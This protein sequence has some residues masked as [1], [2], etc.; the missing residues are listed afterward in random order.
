[1][2]DSSSSSSSLSFSFSLSAVLPPAVL[3]PSA[4][5]TASEEPRLKKK[6]LIFL[7]SRALTKIFG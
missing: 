4:I 3:P 1:M 5:G 6:S 2:S 7:P